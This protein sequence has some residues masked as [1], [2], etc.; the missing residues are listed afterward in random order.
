MEAIFFHIV[1]PILGLL[2]L[3]DLNYSSL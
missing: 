2:G 3:A 1:N